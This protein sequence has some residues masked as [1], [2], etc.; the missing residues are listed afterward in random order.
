MFLVGSG[1]SE[2]GGAGRRINQFPLGV[3][4]HSHTVRCFSAA[5]WRC[6]T[7]DLLSDPPPV[8]WSS[9]TVF[10]NSAASHQHSLTLKSSHV[11]CVCVCDSVAPTKTNHITSYNVDKNKRRPLRSCLP[12]LKE[13]ALALGWP[14]LG[15]VD[16]LANIHHIH[17]NIS[18][19]TDRF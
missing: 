19:L 15:K 12:R 1:V 14:R 16:H 13:G 3:T 8:S 17:I 11:A 10:Y 5:V 6:R 4:T 18:Q 7:F 9:T 2:W